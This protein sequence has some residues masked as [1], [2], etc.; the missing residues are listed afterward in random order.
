MAGAALKG[1]RRAERQTGSLPGMQAASHSEAGPTCKQNETGRLIRPTSGA[2]GDRKRRPSSG[3]RP[4]FQGD[5]QTLPSESHAQWLR[6][7]RER[8]RIV[9]NFDLIAFDLDGTVFPTP[10]SSRR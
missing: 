6:K 2:R 9:P 8:E 7:P 3:T 5:E 1:K 4:C 10:P